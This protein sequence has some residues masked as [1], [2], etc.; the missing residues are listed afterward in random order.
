MKYNNKVILLKKGN[1]R[2]V[3]QVTMDHSSISGAI[4]IKDLFSEYGDP[5]HQS[6]AITPAQHER[7]KSIKI[8]D[9]SAKDCKSFDEFCNKFPELVI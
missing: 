8:I 9:S 5:W 1:G 6:Y 3:A 2:I 7:D 4:L